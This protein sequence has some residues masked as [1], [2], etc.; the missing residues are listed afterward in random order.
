MKNSHFEVTVDAEVM[1]KCQLQYYSWCSKSLKE[2]IYGSSIILVRIQ[3][4]IQAS[5]M[6]TLLSACIKTKAREMYD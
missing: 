6:I 4:Q 2:N 1:T 3:V 5:S